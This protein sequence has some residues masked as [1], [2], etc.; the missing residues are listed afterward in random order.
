M[1]TLYAIKTCEFCGKRRCDFK[2]EESYREHYK[3]H[4]DMANSCSECNKEFSTVLTLRKHVKRIHC[5]KLH[6]TAVTKFVQ[7]ETIFR[8]IK[9]NS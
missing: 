6:V 3:K 2:T 5:E 8:D 7:I 4:F 9:R 1:I